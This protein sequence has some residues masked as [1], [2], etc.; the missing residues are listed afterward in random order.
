M[1]TV[2]RVSLLGLSIGG[3]LTTLTSTVVSFLSAT[4]H[5]PPFLFGRTHLF[6]TFSR[7][8]GV[9]IE[10]GLAAAFVACSLVL[11]R[12]TRRDPRN[13]YAHAFLLATIL[14]GVTLAVAFGRPRCAAVWVASA[15]AAAMLA[16]SVLA[17]RR[18]FRKTLRDVF[19]DARE[20][21]SSTSTL[22]ATAVYLLAVLLM[23]QSISY[24]VSAA[25]RSDSSSRDLIRWFDAQRPLALS[26]FR[27]VNGRKLVV[28]TDYQCPVC[29]VMVPQYRSVVSGLRSAGH[30][31]ELVIKDFPL[32]EECNSGVRTTQHPVSCEAAA[33]MR[34]LAARAPG[35]LDELETW[36]YQQRDRLS[37]DN[38]KGR[39]A[40]MGLASAFAGEYT[41]LVASVSDDARLGLSAGVYSTPAV[42]L[43][44]VKLPSLTAAGIETLAARKPSAPE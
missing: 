35:R 7:V 11:W 4:G 18:S 19:A 23:A 38:L 33:A 27:A 28:F 42:F 13:L 15:C 3:C 40:E 22:S 8:A 1:Q 24:R 37:F 16:I 43:D 36:L 25:A 2:L 26:Q 9:P 30:Q 44:G 41:A 5:V 10:F 21:L 14:L 31:V 34:L 20:A 29:S 32:E 17:D 6:S 12:M 39:L